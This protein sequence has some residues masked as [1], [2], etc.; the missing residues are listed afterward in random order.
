MANEQ[1]E[2]KVVISQDTVDFVRGLSIAGKKLDDFGKDGKFSIN[3]LETALKALKKQFD[4]LDDPLERQ[5]IAPKINEISNGIKTLN[6]QQQ[7]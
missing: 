5:K 7:L 1:V 6:E 4:S 3:S 2:L